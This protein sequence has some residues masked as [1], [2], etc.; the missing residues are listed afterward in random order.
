[1]TG[2]T[3][4]SMRLK[5]PFMSVDPSLTTH[6]MQSVGAVKVPGQS[7]TVARGTFDD[8]PIM[9][10]NVSGCQI[11]IDFT[12]GPDGMRAAMAG[13]AGHAVMSL[14]VSVKGARLF[15]E[16]LVGSDYKCG[17]I[18]TVSISCPPNN[19]IPQIADGI[20]GMA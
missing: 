8:L 6:I 3:F 20:P 10:L 18:G 12:A 1:V 19:L 4:F 13:F 16:P 9:T 14:A 2:L 15:R 5:K 17:H 7:V 11:V